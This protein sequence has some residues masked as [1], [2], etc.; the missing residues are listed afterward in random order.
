ML[1]KITYP[2]KDVFYVPKTC[3][4]NVDLALKVLNHLSFDAIWGAIGGSQ[5]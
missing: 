4:G 3:K 1:S 5:D 2:Y